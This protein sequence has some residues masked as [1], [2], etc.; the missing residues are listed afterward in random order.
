MSKNIF[1]AGK[2]LPLVAP[3]AEGFVLKENHV[4]L[5]LSEKDEKSDIPSGVETVEWERGSSLACKNA[6]IQAETK[7]G[8]ADDFIFYY[9]SAYYSSVFKDFSI[10]NCTKATDTLISSFQFLSLEV[11][12]RIRQHKTKSRLIFILKSQPDFKDVKLSLALKNTIENP[13][14]PFVAAGEAAFA[15][16]AENIASVFAEEKNI[17]VLLVA[18]DNQNETMKNES[19]FSSWLNSYIDSLDGLKSK[20]PLKNIVNWVKAGSKNPGGFSLFH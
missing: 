9:D 4:V 17:S 8:F 1:I 2:E 11:L 13:S 20:L 3:F 14:N 6:L 16:F 12:N 15:T 7:T 19:D 18:G 5:F 10:E